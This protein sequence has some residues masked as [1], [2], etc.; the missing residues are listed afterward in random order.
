MREINALAMRAAV[1]RFFTACIKIIR[2]TV[3]FQQYTKRKIIKRTV[4]NGPRRIMAMDFLEWSVSFV[5]FPHFSFTVIRDARTIAH[6]REISPHQSQLHHFNLL[7]SL[8]IPR[9]IVRL[10]HNFIETF[11]TRNIILM[12][13]WRKCSNVQMCQFKMCS[14]FKKPFFLFANVCNLNS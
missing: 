5:I 14:A 13:R 12:E 7:I 4:H 10:L 1:L 11:N 6:L 3:T 9:R 8:K 2:D